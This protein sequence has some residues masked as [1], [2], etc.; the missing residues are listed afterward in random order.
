MEMREKY[1]GVKWDVLFRGKDKDGMG[2]HD[3]GVIIFLFLVKKDEN[4]SY[5]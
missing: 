5:T 4:Y 2:F 1:V 3:I